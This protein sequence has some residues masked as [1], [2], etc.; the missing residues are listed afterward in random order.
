MKDV[1]QFKARFFLGKAE[2]N[3]RFFQG[4]Q[5]GLTALQ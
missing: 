1:W 5:K 4:I 2:V 3:K